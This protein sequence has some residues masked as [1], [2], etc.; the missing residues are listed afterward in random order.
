LTLPF[1]DGK[2]TIGPT[3]IRRIEFRE[4]ER[5]LITASDEDVNYCGFSGS[6]TPSFDA[7]DEAF[8]G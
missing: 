5:Y 8:G 7:F 6:A 1:N 3:L 2:A 4:G